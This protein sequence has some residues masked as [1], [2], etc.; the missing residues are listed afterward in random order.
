MYDKTLIRLLAVESELSITACNACHRK[1][2][3]ILPLRRALVPKSAKGWT[4]RPD[5]ELPDVQLGLRTLR[6]GYL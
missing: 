1:G 3:P 5:P 2:L 6:N 4:S